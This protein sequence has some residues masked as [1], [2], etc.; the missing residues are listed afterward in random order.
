MDKESLKINIVKCD[1][2]EQIMTEMNLP[3]THLN[4]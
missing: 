4:L 2:T 1:D 3:K